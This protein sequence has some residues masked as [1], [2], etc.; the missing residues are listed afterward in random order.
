VRR[1]SVAGWALAF[2]LDVA[3]C[4]GHAA[5]PAS[6]SAT[7]QPISDDVI[8]RTTF[9]PSLGVHLDQMLRHASGLY[10]QDVHVGTGAVALAGKSMVVRYVG[11]LSDGKKFDSG[12]I[13]VTIGSSSTI[14]AWKEG[15][16]GMRVG[17]QRRLVSPPNLAYGSRGAGS[18]IP[19][20]AVLVFD[21][22]MVAAI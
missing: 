11:Y 6:V 3:G 18:D 2:A 17:G 7:P 22:E 16:L 14:Q 9:A 21:I 15:L 5:A 8:T 12:E 1:L 13:T 20:Y 19:P 10:V 4:A